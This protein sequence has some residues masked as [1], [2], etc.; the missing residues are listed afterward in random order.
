M[1][2][3]KEQ[4]EKIKK[5]G[6]VSRLNE[7]KQPVFDEEQYYIIESKMNKNVCS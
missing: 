7:K 1:R 6:L 2:Y 4:L 5:N 3:T